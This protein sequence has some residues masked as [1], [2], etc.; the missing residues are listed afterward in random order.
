MRPFQSGPAVP[1]P[2][3][4]F[5]AF[6]HQNR[7]CQSHG[8]CPPE[9]QCTHRGEACRRQFAKATGRVLSQQFSCHCTIQHDLNPRF[10][11]MRSRNSLFA[12]VDSRRANYIGLDAWQSA[13]SAS[14]GHYGGTPHVPSNGCIDCRR[15]DPAWAERLGSRTRQRKMSINPFDEDRRRGGATAEEELARQQEVVDLSIGPQQAGE[16]IRTTLPW[17]PTMRILIRATSS[18]NRLTVAE[19]LPRCVSPPNNRACS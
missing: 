7:L 15:G 3:L 8:G 19:L 5:H 13:G 14:S 10:S 17:A 9:C 11:R 1:L 6:Q 16:T 4:S 18:S 12:Y 2:L